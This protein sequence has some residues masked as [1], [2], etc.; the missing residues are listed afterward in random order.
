MELPGNKD[1]IVE[2]AKDI[3][4]KLLNLMGVSASVTPLSEFPAEGATGSMTFN[5]EGEDL[6]ILIGR[7][8][9]TLSCLQY[10]VRLIVGH[11]TGLWRPITIDVEGYKQRRCNALRD[12]AWRMA[13]QVKVKK[14]PFSLEPM[15]AFDRRIIHLALVDHPDVTTQSSGEGEARRVVILPKEQL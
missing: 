4:E 7:R 12:L 14:V 3:L 10:L 13:E 8:G 9:Q 2:V 5:V 1:E 6:G 15:P 11:Q